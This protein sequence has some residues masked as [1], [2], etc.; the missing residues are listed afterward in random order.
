MEPN[1][2]PDDSVDESTADVTRFPVETFVAK[3]GG[4]TG[5]FLI[6]LLGGFL[7]A[8]GLA[9]LFNLFPQFSQTI[10]ILFPIALGC[11]LGVGIGLVGY[12]VRARSG[13]GSVAILVISLMCGAVTYAGF[14]V[15]YF[16]SGH[17]PDT[18]NGES[19]FDSLDRRAKKGYVLRGKRGGKTNFGY[20]GTW[21]YWTIELAI[22]SIGAMIVARLIT[23]GPY[24]EICDQWNRCRTFG[25]FPFDAVAGHLAFSNGE[26]TRMFVPGPHEHKVKIE[27]YD[28]PTCP[29][30]PLS[31]RY[32]GTVG[33]GKK[34]VTH[35]SF[36]VY[37]HGA[38]PAFEAIEMIANRRDG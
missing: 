32:T 24:C 17:D 37:P 19:F 25:P 34:M 30:D 23:K 1:E 8:I 31:I 14:H 2:R 13:Q 38:L 11:L 33:S 6:V 18:V 36:L 15:A 5:R 35:S 29:E 20:T 7:W 27:V 4:T 10:F 21:I 16:Q 3:G 26:P 9:F 28:C 12:K 22:T